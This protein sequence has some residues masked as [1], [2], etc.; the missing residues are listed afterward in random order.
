MLESGGQERGSFVSLY[1]IS[2][3]AASKAL[4]EVWEAPKSLPSGST[5]LV[6]SIQR[7]M[8][9]NRTLLNY[10]FQLSMALDPKRYKTTGGSFIMGA[11]LCHEAHIAEAEIKG[12]PLPVVDENAFKEMAA[13]FLKPSKV[14][15]RTVGTLGLPLGVD[16][17]SAS[18]ALIL[19]AYEEETYL[20][21]AVEKAKEL[22]G[23][24]ADFIQSGA[25]HV[26]YTMKMAERA[27]QKRRPPSR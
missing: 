18:H 23:G 24:P 2:E 20:K 13:E 9:L 6:G 8:T 19:K 25:T 10:V 26:L 27:A 14:D 7:F 3:Q 16:L 15:P 21:D 22:M 4:H 11:T 5:E 12:V 17:K 1:P